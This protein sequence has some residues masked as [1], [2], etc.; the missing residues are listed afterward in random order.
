MVEIFDN[1]KKIYRFSAPCP[2]LSDDIEFFSES[3]SENTALY[4]AGKC[5]TVKMFPS[6][7]P[8]FWINLGSPY[9]LV[10]GKGQYHLGSDDDVL[11]LRNSIAERHNLPSDHIFTVK[12]YPG[13][14]ESILGINQSGFADK[15][16]PLNSVMPSGLIHEIKKA[17]D[18]E[19]RMQILQQYFLSHRKKKKPDHYLRFVHDTIGLFE[20]SA[21]RFNNNEMAEK[22]FTSSKTI[23]RYFNAIIGTSPK[24]YFSILRARSALTAY[25]ADKKIF[26][27]AGFG[28]YDM[29][30]FY[31][32]IRKF[33]GQPMTVNKA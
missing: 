31:R 10:L 2:E 6:W 4:M 13:G 5:F 30:H 16:I 24:N 3:S 9:Q 11:V 20:D 1:I 17:D 14:F 15:V 7:T 18:F 19:K 26:D 33:T 27:P 12:F 8:T 23:N 29:S 32:E 25:L 28:Y 21:M 22:M